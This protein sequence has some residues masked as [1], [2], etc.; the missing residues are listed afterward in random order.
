MNHSNFTTRL[1]AMALLLALLASLLCL[2]LGAAKPDGTL[3]SYQVTDGADGTFSLRLL[4][5]T[6]SLRYDKFGYEIKLTTMDAEGNEVTETY[7]GEAEQVY[8]SVLGGETEYS[9]KELFGYEYAAIATITGLDAAS[10]YTKIEVSAYFILH[11]GTISRGADVT[12]YYTGETNPQGYPL[13]STTHEPSDPEPDIP[14]PDTPTQTTSKL[15]AL[16]STA[17]IPSID[18]SELKG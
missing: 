2:P 9:I 4:A 5:G 10:E 1:C 7:T 8:S 17:T 16:A 12:L 18:W 11:V 14:E 13:L 3:I 15:A 6:N